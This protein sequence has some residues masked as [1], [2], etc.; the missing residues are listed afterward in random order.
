MAAS[1]GRRPCRHWTCWP[2]PLR[3]DGRCRAANSGNVRP[4]LGVKVDRERSAPYVPH[5][6]LLLR[7]LAAAADALYLA[8][9]SCVF[10]VHRIVRIAQILLVR[11]VTGARLTMTDRRLYD[12]LVRIFLDAR[13]Y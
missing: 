1:T 12:R 4:S 13:R 3:R 6:R 11:H 9:E 8:V 2:T 7:D 10:L 5:R